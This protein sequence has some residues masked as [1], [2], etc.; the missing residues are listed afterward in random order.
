MAEPAAPLLRALGQSL[1]SRSHALGILGVT[2]RS[3]YLYVCECGTNGDMH[4]SVH[5]LASCHELPDCD[6]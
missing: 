6:L 4:G 2:H 1:A 3:T 5:D